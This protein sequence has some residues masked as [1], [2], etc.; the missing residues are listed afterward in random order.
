MVYSNLHPISHRFQGKP[1]VSRI[2]SNGQNFA[3]TWVAVF[4]THSLGI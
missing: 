3:M 2:T 1:T 4:S